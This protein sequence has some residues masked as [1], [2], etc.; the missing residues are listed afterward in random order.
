MDEHYGRPLPGHL[1]HQARAGAFQHGGGAAARPGP[2]EDLLSAHTRIVAR[3]RRP[4]HRYAH[5]IWA[6]G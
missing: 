6:A 3:G 5:P 1:V 2:G 4:R